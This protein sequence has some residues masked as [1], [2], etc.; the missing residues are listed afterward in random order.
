MEEDTIRNM[1]NAHLLSMG[2]YPVRWKNIGHLLETRANETPGKS[3]ITFYDDDESA[4][5]ELSYRAFDQLVNKTAN[6]L[7]SIGIKQNDKVTTVMYNHLQTVVIYFACWK[8][9]ACVVPI[10][11]EDESD[12]IKFIT[13]NLRRIAE[14]ASDIAEIVL[15][16][17]VEHTLKQSKA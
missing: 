6:F 8:I 11:V 12:R 3:F 13:E 16:M 4:R 9:G 7:L 17:T 1:E 15:N 5:K 2:D 10:N 14:Y